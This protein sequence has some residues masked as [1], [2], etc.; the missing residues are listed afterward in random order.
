MERLLYILYAIVIVI[1]ITDINHSA[2]QSSSWGG[3]SSGRAGY[4]SNGAHK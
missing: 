4:W 2:I 3:G 1:V